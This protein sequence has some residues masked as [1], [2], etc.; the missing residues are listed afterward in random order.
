MKASFEPL[1][2]LSDIENNTINPIPTVNPA[3]TGIAAL[4]LL[5]FIVKLPFYDLLNLI[6]LFFMV[7]WAINSHFVNDK[8]DV[9]YLENTSCISDRITSVSKPSYQYPSIIP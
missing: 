4:L 9:Q 2:G 6:H 5:P 7:R 8:C 3:I 1:S